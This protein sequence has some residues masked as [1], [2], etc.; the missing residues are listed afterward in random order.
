MLFCLPF[1]SSDDCNG[2]LKLF[3]GRIWHSVPRVK[4]HLGN[5]MAIL[6]LALFSRFAACVVRSKSSRNRYVAVRKNRSTCHFSQNL[7]H[8][9]HAP[10]SGARCIPVSLQT[11]WWADSLV[12]WFQWHPGRRVIFAPAGRARTVVRTGVVGGGHGV[13][14]N[15]MVVIPIAFWLS[16]PCDTV[17]CYR[18][19][20]HSH[21]S[22]CRNWCSDD[23]CRFT[24]NVKLVTTLVWHE[25]TVNLGIWWYGSNLP[26]FSCWNRSIRFF[27]G[28][29]K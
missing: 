22:G 27:T 20:R 21:Q 12:M 7:S 29:E 26:R 4:P 15:Q 17:C 8:H 10:A 19:F 3:A 9:L 11:S 13:P 25:C 23:R 14:R 5:A 1:C 16:D 24:W 28:P 18:F 6:F 2:L